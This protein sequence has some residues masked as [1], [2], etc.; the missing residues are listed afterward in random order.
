MNEGGSAAMW[1]L[2]SKTNEAV[3]LKS[4][5]FRLA[6]ELDEKT[7]IGLVDY[8]DFENAGLPE[9]NTLYPYVHKRLSFS[10]EKEVRAVILKT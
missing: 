8:I 7:Y 10:H 2:Y 9:G 6:N 3:A 4:T 5:F 1:Q